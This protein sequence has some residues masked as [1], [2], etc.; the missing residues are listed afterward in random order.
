MAGIDLVSRSGTRD[1]KRLGFYLFIKKIM[2]F[3]THIAH[4]MNRAT[5]PRPDT[6]GDPTHE[7][8]HLERRRL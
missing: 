1:L 5:C 6:H 3:D 2:Y 4:V 7:P 8:F